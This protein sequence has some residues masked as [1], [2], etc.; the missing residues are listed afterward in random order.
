MLRKLFDFL[1][2]A[3]HWTNRPCEQTMAI[4]IS[5]STH[6]F[7]VMS[8]GFPN[9]GSITEANRRESTGAYEAILAAGAMAQRQSRP[10]PLIIQRI[11]WTSAAERFLLQSI[12]V[13][14]WE[15]PSDYSLDRHWTLWCL[16][17]E[18]LR[19][20]PSRGGVWMRGEVGVYLRFFRR[21]QNSWKRLSGGT[22][23]R[24][25]NRYGK[26]IVTI[27]DVFLIPGP[28][29]RSKITNTFEQ[30]AAEEAL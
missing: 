22:E 15:C 3:V 16:T 24:R 23:K 29:S 4:K 9:R 12:F 19:S 26:M 25:Q 6:T 13:H 30:L 1:L 14:Q 2:S 7:S 11:E 27:V 21:R 28:I 17:I 20:I 18:K 5:N 8:A 10:E